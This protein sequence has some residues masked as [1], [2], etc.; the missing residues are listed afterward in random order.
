MKLEGQ[1]R[2]IVFHEK[3]GRRHAHAVW[4]RIDTEHMRAVP[5]PFFKMKL[6]DVG[7]EQFLEN[8]WQLPSGFVNSKERDPA[9]YSLGE[10][11]Q[12]KRAGHDPKAL[13]GMFQE[14]W[15]ASD[16]G[17]AFAA[18]LQS[19][20]Y[21]L[22]CGDSKRRGHVAVDWRGEV[23]AI[24]RYTGQRTKDVRARLGSTTNGSA[25]W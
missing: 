18:A 7:R 11:Q 20:G 15:A 21:T 12:A 3:D 14:L 16:S 13:K 22:A 25:R 4:S 6:R 8:G 17:R 24:A 1:S 9:S 5:L 23:Y 2:A 19:R 10:W